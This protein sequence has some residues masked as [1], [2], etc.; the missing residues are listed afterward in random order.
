MCSMLP[1]KSPIR[2]QPG[3]GDKTFSQEGRFCYL[4]SPSRKVSWETDISLI[5]EQLSL[6]TLG[7]LTPRTHTLDLTSNQREAKRVYRRQI[8][9]RPI[10]HYCSTTSAKVLS[11]FPAP[12]PVCGPGQRDLQAYFNGSAPA[13][14]LG[15]L[16][17]G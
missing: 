17:W 11:Q 6:T 5:K 12:L 8:C 10:L 3:R 7:V 2:F 14:R 15:F 9:R 1:G 16:S 4:M 13:P